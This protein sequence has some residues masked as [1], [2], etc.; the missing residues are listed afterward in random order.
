[1]RLPALLLL[2]ASLLSATAA[3]AQDISL[4]ATEKGISIN[5][6]MNVGNGQFNL[7]PPN[8]I[9]GKDIYKPVKPKVEF[10]D[11]R[12]LTLHYP[13]G[14]EIKVTISELNITFAYSGLPADASSISM[15]MNIS[16][17]AWQGSRFSFGDS[18]LQPFP[19]EDSR[20]YLFEGKANLFTFVDPANTGM[21][22]SSPQVLFKLLNKGPEGW[23]QFA[24]ICSFPVADHAGGTEFSL[25]FRPVTAQ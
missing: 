25:E 18:P 17:D 15:R 1:M 11:D 6:S 19:E 23:S 16:R 13:N 2:C 8:I 10:V 24:G 21:A 20:K 7:E 5:T 22:I 9:I 4:L 3:P 14:A 12:Q